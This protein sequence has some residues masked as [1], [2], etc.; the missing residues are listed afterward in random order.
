MRSKGRILKQPYDKNT[1]LN[2]YLTVNTYSSVYALAFKV[3]TFWLVSRRSNPHQRYVY[4]SYILYNFELYK[5]RNI[6]E[7][8]KFDIHNYVQLEN[9]VKNLQY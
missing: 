9:P 7:K 6:T 2:D 3:N 8:Y 4:I 5:I 1:W